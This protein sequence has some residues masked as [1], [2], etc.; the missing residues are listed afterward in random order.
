VRTI[1]DELTDKLGEDGYEAV[2]RKLL[3]LTRDVTRLKSKR[4]TDDRQILAQMEGT[5]D[6]S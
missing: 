3:T 5:H 6:D 1:E 2:R 4:E